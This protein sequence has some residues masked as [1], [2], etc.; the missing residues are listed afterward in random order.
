MND[1]PI[2]VLLIEDNPGDAH[3]IQKTLTQAGNG[4]FTLEWAERLSAG[5]ECLAEKEIDLILL[6]LSLPDSQGLKTLSQTHALAPQ[7]PIVVLTGLDDDTLAAQAISQGAQD[8]LIKSQVVVGHGDLLVRAMRYAIKRKQAE[9]ASRRSEEHYRSMFEGLPIGLYRTTTEGQFLDANPALVRMLGYPDHESLLKVNSADLYVEPEGRQHWQEVVRREGLVRDFTLQLRRYDG[10]VIWVRDN[11]RVIRDANGHVLYYEGSLEDI[12]ERRQAEETLKYRLEQ[13]A[14]LSRASQ[15][16]IASLNLDQVLDEIV[17]LTSEVT[18]SDH[19]SVVLVDD[20]GGLIQSAQDLPTIKYLARD[21]GIT[22]WVI[23]AREAVIIEVGDQ[24]H[25]IPD[26]GPDAP[27]SVNPLI[28]ETGVKSIAALPLI[29]KDNLLGVLNLYSLRPGMF[30][31]QLPLLTTFANQA[32][33]AIENARLY[34]KTQQELIERQRAEAQARRRTE[35]MVIVHTIGQAI[36][37]NLERPQVME[38]VLGG[39]KHLLKVE[40]CSLLLYDPVENN[41]VFEAASGVGADA[42]LGMRLELGQGVAGWVALTDESLLVPDVSQDPRFYAG[43]DVETGLTTRSLVAVPIEIGGKRVGVIEA[44][45]VGDRRFS[46][47]DLDLLRI[48]SGPVATAIQNAQ[49]FEEIKQYSDH[50]E[51]LVTERTEELQEAKDR[52]ETILDSVGDPIVLTDLS[53]Y[54]LDVNPAFEQQTGYSPDEIS[55]LQ[56]DSLFDLDPA[57]GE[58]SKNTL[59]QIRDLAL[60]QDRWRG[61]L[62]VRRKGGST[63]DADVIVGTTHDQTGQ[64]TGFVSSIRDISKLKEVDRLKDQF[65]SDVSHELRTPLANIK[66]SL[67][68]LDHSP[69]EQHQR[70]LNTLAHEQAR[71]EHL[72]ENLLDLSRLDLGAVQA[73]RMPLDIDHLVR[74]LVL[75][76]QILATAKGLQLVTQLASEEPKPD[77]RAAPS[78]HILPLVLADGRML[79]QVLDNLLTNAFLYTPPPGKVTVRTSTYQQEGE[80]WVVISIC[81]TGLGILPE[82]RE[83]IFNRFHRGAAAYQTGVQGTGLGLAICREIVERHQ[84]RI[85]VE[86][87]PGIGSTFT[88]HLPAIAPREEIDQTILKVQSRDQ[89]LWVAAPASTLV[90]AGPFIEPLEAI[91]PRLLVVED[92]ANLLLG[93]REALCNAGYQVWTAKHGLEGLEV[94]DQVEPDLVI[95]DVMMPRMDGFAFCQAVRERPGGITTPFI[96][97]TAK[98]QREARRHGIAL[99]AEDYVVKP[100]DLEDLLHLVSARLQR[101]AEVLAIQQA[102]V[103]DLKNRIATM[104]THE[105]RTPLTYITTYTSMLSEEAAE[106]KDEQFRHM[107]TGIQ[108]GSE[109]L[110]RLV[111]DFLMLI[112]LETGIAAN[113]YKLDHCLLPHPGDWIAQVVDRYR[114]QAQAT[115]LALHLDLADDLPPIVASPTYLCEALGRLLDNAIKFSKSFGEQVMVEAKSQEAELRIS[116][117]DEGIGIPTDHLDKIFTPFHQVNREKQE[118]SGIGVGLA[119]AKGLIDLHG[120]RIEVESQIGSGTTFAVFLPVR[121]HQ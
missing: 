23:N 110:S 91:G 82:E 62:V 70:Y 118:Q 28:L 74:S 10:T 86:S 104:L 114:S 47:E 109:R 42:V 60:S 52:V 16:V 59:A 22:S 6:D 9:D 67:H 35:Q 66:L 63:Y 98:G 50:L 44:M 57:N 5:L 89:S 64:V 120:G 103:T 13:L 11:T 99:G 75:D 68:L 85:E 72:V 92:D 24:G 77:A 33:I 14:A 27:R 26:L 96:F 18:D 65:V 55:G 108:H 21:E 48:L 100:F 29:A 19:T 31:D 107:L 32:A 119:I 121:N 8:Y 113:N 73:N 90:S 38:T 37:S 106:L 1:R 111:F 71:L 17:S 61:E 40:A 7:T 4:P 115:G 80:K 34:E 88:V 15:F 76:R 116:I 36:T 83:Q 51:K 69:P 87:E 43:V 53:G 93:L 45:S 81:D 117:K 46:E 105:F 58:N 79:V 12:T 94:F 39:I 54:L 20:K 95:S 101:R 30:Y 25:I 49:L 41:L 56:F 97:L 78:E 102:E 84:G 3:L 112:D 2:K